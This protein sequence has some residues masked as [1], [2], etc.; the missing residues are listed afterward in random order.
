MTVPAEAEGRRDD[1][2][3]VA[4]VVFMSMNPTL[5]P[6]TALNAVVGIWLIL[7]LVQR[8]G[9]RSYDF[10]IAL[11]VLVAGLICTSVMWASNLQNSLQG[12]IS[13]LIYTILAV[14][15]VASMSVER[16][17]QGVATGFKVILVASIMAI[18]V[19]PSTAFVTAVYQSGSFQGL[20][21]HR[22][23]MGYLACL[24][25]LVF[26]YQWFGRG[27]RRLRD[28]IWVVLAIA[29]VVMTRSVTSLLMTVLW[30]L[31]LLIAIRLIRSKSK[32]RGF[33]AIAL[34]ALAVT[35]GTVA[36]INFAEFTDQLGRDATL[37]GRTD[38]WETV[39]MHIEQRPIFGFGWASVWA[40]GDSVG[41]SIRGTLGFPISHAHNGFLND[42]LQ[43][44]W[45]GASLI[46]VC[47]AVAVITLARQTVRK[48]SP[49]LLA[50]LVIVLTV[51]SFNFV[52]A[53]LTLNLGWFAF[54]LF[55]A[56]ASRAS[57]SARAE[58]EGV[59]RARTGGRNLSPQ[60]L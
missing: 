58:R 9:K 19:S 22:N 10:R 17:L 33:N 50:G 41:D 35:G 44:G 54:V 38:I 59:S 32:F 56:Q 37:T 39:L 21:S 3:F 18:A 51:V 49:S 53:R 45:A 1:I 31:V 14:H 40:I 5:M 24:A 43:L 46:V 55:Y 6:Q 27:V 12:A 52:E 11:P 28:G 60:H 20:A 26:L 15:V 36:V 42:A 34:F 23:Y 48:Q 7:R 8:D 30:G 13:F 4:L 47:I 29:V 57:R 25:T 2:P 16:S